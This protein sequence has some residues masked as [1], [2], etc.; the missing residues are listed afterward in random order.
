MLFKK[1]E[2]WRDKKGNIRCPGNMCPK[3]CD[4]ACPIWQNTCGLE[5]LAQSRPDQAI[6]FFKRAIDIAPDF[7]D[8]HNNLGSAYGICNRHREALESFNKALSLRS[9]YLHALRGKII[10]EKNLGMYEDA[11]SLCNVY[12]LISGESAEKYRSDIRKLQSNCSPSRSSW[13]TLANNLL[14]EG[15]KSG[16]IQSTGLSFI[17]EII[18]QANI[19]C[20][21]LVASLLK[22]CDKLNK[23]KTYNIILFSWAAY[24]GM[25]SVY[26]WNRNW[27][28]LNKNGIYNTLTKERGIIEMDE[29]VLD[30]IGLPFASAEGRN[31][32]DFVYVLAAKVEIKLLSEAKATGHLID[33]LSGAKAMFAFGMIL[34][35]NRLGMK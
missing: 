21:D 24:A 22:E 17:P 5:K 19:V 10:A 29:Y 30:C 23:M 31:M 13:T 20:Q 15:R 2:V 16:Y 3:G 34:E 14:D 1:R 32:S 35:M 26:H 7:P 28:A 6:G 4:E 27:P 18:S 12:E 8:A 25:G 9:N 33:L 11:L